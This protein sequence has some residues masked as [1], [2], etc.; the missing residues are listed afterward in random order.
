MQIG[1]PT[2]GWIKESI[3]ASRRARSIGITNKIPILLLQAEEDTVVHNKAQD[4]F[5]NH[6]D[7][8][9][10]VIMGHSKHEILME[11]DFIRNKALDCIRNFILQKIETLKIK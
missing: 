3:N 11:I 9:E 1:G 5:I 7:N 10:K 2:F 6:C 8:I 4:K